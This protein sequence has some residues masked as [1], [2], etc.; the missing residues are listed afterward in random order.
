MYKQIMH[1]I[2]K[3]TYTFGIVRE[4]WDVFWYLNLFIQ[5]NKHVVVQTV[6]TQQLGKCFGITEIW[7]LLKGRIWAVSGEIGTAGREKCIFY[8][9]PYVS[10]A[11]V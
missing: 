5:N 8:G 2:M 1:C 6:Q 11:A 7:H 10:K 9:R 3:I 4:S